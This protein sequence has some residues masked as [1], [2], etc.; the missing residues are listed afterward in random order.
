MDER[1]VLRAAD[2]VRGMP[3]GASVDP[4]PYC[5]GRVS[6]RKGWIHQC[7]PCGGVGVFTKPARDPETGERHG[8]NVCR[9][10]SC[11]EPCGDYGGCRE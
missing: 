11:Q 7:T 1:G 10:G 8:W 2:I 5:N 4:C 6:L 3:E 9:Y